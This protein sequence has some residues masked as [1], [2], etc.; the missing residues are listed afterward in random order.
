MIFLYKKVDCLFVVMMS[1]NLDCVGFETFSQILDDIFLSKMFTQNIWIIMMEKYGKSSDGQNIKT[2]KNVKTILCI[3][4]P[5]CTLL[6]D[7]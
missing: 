2:K 3:S 6:M 5:C 4:N 1:F 7:L